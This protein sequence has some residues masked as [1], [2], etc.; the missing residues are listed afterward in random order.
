M[1]KGNGKTQATAWDPMHTG[2]MM[3]PESLAQNEHSLIELIPGQ[4][5]HGRSMTHV[6]LRSRWRTVLLLLGAILMNPS[7]EAGPTLGPDTW[8]D[9]MV[10]AAVL[11]QQGNKRDACRTAMAIGRSLYEHE[12]T[13]LELTWMPSVGRY[14][15]AMPA[16]EPPLRGS[17]QR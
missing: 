7:V 12:A 14:C 5:P 17:D 2:E 6:N 4:S 13:K 10:M 9:F 3:S 1:A 8:H 16:A 11:E 15:G